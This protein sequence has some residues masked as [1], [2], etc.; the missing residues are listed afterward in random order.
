MMG[1]GPGGKIVQ[2][3]HNDNNYPRTR[4]LESSV[5]INIQL[6][7]TLD[8]SRITGFRPPLTP[9]TRELYRERGIPWS[10]SYDDE[11][12]TVKTREGQKAFKDLRLIEG[13]AHEGE[14]RELRFITALPCGG[15]F[16]SE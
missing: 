3:I 11:V 4:D 15:K 16:G 2:R 10:V 13:T 14:T 8:F 12:S 9:I 6:L 5:L 7:N 1:P